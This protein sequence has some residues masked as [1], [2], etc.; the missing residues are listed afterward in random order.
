MNDPAFWLSPLTLTFD[1]QALGH[2]KATSVDVEHEINGIPSA[3][4]TLALVTHAFGDVW[5]KVSDD[6]ALCEPGTTLRVAVSAGAHA[7]PHVLFDGVVVE[8]RLRWQQSQPELIVRARHPLY[9][10]AGAARNRVH[11]DRSDAEVM[12]ALLREHHVATGGFAANAAFQAPQEQLIQWASSDWQWLRSRLHAHGVWLVPGSGQ[13]SCIV[14][15][16]AARPHH[17]VEAQ[18]TNETDAAVLDGEWIFDAQEQ[19]HGVDVAYWDVHRQAPSAT[20]RAQAAPLGSEGLNPGRVRSLQ[21][22]PWRLFHAVPLGVDEIQSQADARLLAQHAAAVQVRMRVPGSPQSLLYELGQT[23]ALRGFGRHFSGRGILAGVAHR[24][25]QGLFETTITLGQDALRPVD[26]ALLPRAPGMTVGVVDTYAADARS[27]YRIPVRLP[28]LDNQVV[29]ARFAQPYATQGGG[30]C[31][32][33]EPGDEVVLAFLDEDPRHPVILGATH[34][35]MRQPPFPMGGTVRGLVFAAA[36]DDGAAACRLVFDTEAGVTL[37]AANVAIGGDERVT[38]QA[39]TE[40]AM[41]S[42]D[43]LDVKAKDA[44]LHASNRVG[45]RGEEGVEIAGRKIDLNT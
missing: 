9:R 34:N 19:P 14:P 5:R 33:P 1:T 43:K 8:Q 2:M 21:T 27:L 38:L 45:M 3:R 40:L 6:A 15:E 41:V 29:R 36:E 16:L 18:R 44:T 42:S 24:W 22:Q 10:L 17:T 13:V 20:R 23:L 28:A 26:A 32:Y 31:L 7:T 12:R 39:G 4:I 35:D 25:E 30:L 11:R 37:Q